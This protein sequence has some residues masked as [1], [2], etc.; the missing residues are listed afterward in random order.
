MRVWQGTE[1]QI[2]DKAKTLTT[3]T[4]K[5][6]FRIGVGQGD[7]PKPGLVI[8]ISQVYSFCFWPSILLPQC[9][10][11]GTW[12]YA[13]LLCAYKLDGWTKSFTSV[14]SLLFTVHQDVPTSVYL[15]YVLRKN[16]ILKFIGLWAQHNSPTALPCPAVKPFY[17]PCDTHNMVN[18]AFIWTFFGSVT[19]FFLDS[20]AAR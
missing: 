10:W 15:F 12:T 9:L 4:N 13:L 17:W 3:T 5:K 16:T 7:H 18:I 19:P 20:S 2:N 1:Y 14:F 6:P 8:V 11:M